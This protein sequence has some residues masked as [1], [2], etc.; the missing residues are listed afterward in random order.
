VAAGTGAALVL[1]GSL[2]ALL[3]GVAPRDPLSMAAAAVLM[4]AVAAAATVIPARRA[5]RVEPAVALR[6]E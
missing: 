6:E 4:C 2:R 5:T 3:Y 1:T